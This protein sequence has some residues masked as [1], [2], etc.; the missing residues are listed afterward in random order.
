MESSF[1]FEP[2]PLSIRKAKSEIQNFQI[3]KRLKDNSNYN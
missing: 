1:N 2:I 3:F